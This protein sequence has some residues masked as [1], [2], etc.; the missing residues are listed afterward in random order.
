[1]KCRQ[2]DVIHANFFSP[3]YGTKLDFALLHFSTTYCSRNHRALLRSSF[4]TFPEFAVITYRNAKV[5]FRGIATV[6]NE[7]HTD[8]LRRLWDAVR[9]K[10]PEK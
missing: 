4:K 10:R 7:M 8:I 9:R 6:N 1:M 3:N 5:Y 2:L